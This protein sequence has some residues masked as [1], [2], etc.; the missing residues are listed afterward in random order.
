MKKFARM[1][2]RKDNEGNPV[3]IAVVRG[4]K[5]ELIWALS[6]ALWGNVYLFPCHIDMTVEDANK[7]IQNEKMKGY[8]GY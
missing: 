1:V 8:G 4:Y 5:E 3:C 6:K 7:P 2:L